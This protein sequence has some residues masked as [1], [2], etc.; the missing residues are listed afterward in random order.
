MKEVGTRLGPF[1]EYLR[2]REDEEATKEL[3]RRLAQF[4]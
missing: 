3:E 2:A 1:V 4:I